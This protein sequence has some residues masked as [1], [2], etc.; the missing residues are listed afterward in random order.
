[1]ADFELSSFTLKVPRHKKT[2]VRKTQPKIRL[3]VGP[4]NL[5]SNPTI[6]SQNPQPTFQP[7]Q[8]ARQA[9]TRKAQSLA[10][11]LTVNLL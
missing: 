8:P 7:H 2:R 1:M 10:V 9:S 3:G 11:G 4:R 5:P 6:Q